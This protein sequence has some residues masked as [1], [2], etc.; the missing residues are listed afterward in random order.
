[1][2]RK[3][4]KRWKIYFIN[5]DEPVTADFLAAEIRNEFGG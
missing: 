4:K 2:S 5:L 3:I 1:V